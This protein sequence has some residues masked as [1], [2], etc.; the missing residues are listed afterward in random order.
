MSDRVALYKQAY[1]RVV[2]NQQ[3]VWYNDTYAQVVPDL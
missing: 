1:L 2:L 3:H